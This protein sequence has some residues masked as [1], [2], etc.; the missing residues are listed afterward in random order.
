MVTISTLNELN[1]LIIISHD[2]ENSMAI[3]DTAFILANQEGK[4]GATITEKIDLMEMGF[5]WD[6][7]IKKNKSFQ[8]LV[9]QMK[10]R[11]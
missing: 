8:D 6:P 11:M 5:C 4:E 2:I 7:E 1:T 3:S 10:F 9:A